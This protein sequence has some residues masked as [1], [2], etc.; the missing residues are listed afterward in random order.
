MAIP[1]AAD[2]AAKWAQNLG[3]STQRIQSGVQAVTTPPGQAAARQK[4]VWVQ[5]TTSAAN[6]WASNTAAVPLQTWQSDMINKG[7]PRIASGAQAA[8]PKMQAFMGQLLPYIANQVQA[9]PARGDLETNINRMTSFVRGMSKFRN[10]PQA[11]A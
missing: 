10:N 9:L 5:N 3:A 8:Q 11:M 6:K 2:A 1:S 7:I 4:N